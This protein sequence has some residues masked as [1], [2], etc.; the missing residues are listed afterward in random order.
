MALTA[1]FDSLLSNNDLAGVLIS[2][3][4]CPPVIGVD[5]VS[6]VVSCRQMSDR[7]LEYLKSNNIQKVIIVGRWSYALHEDNTTFEGSTSYNDETR[8]RNIR[9]GLHHT[10][11]SFAENDIQ[12]AFMMPVPGAKEDVPQTLA[13]SILLGR[14]AHIEYSREDYQAELTSLDD[15]LGSSPVHANA[16][17]SVTDFLCADI[18]EVKRDGRSL[19]FDSNHPS[20]YMN[21]LLMPL[22]EEQLGL[23]INQPTSSGRDATSSD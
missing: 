15:I 19:Y 18:C 14:P 16:V 12:F 9:E 23:F 8:N 17:I 11:R 1:T 2:V 4:G 6:W 22:V 21:Q 10:F 5:R 13:R 7:V 20:A 3:P